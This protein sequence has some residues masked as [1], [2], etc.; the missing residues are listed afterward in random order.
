MSIIQEALKKAQ[1]DLKKRPVF[2]PIAY[3]NK[4]EQKKSVE[5]KPAEKPVPVYAVKAAA[6]EAAAKKP[7]PA[8][9]IAITLFAALLLAAGLV[10]TRYFM[11]VRKDGVLTSPELM[12]EAAVES[13][14]ESGLYQS[15]DAYKE[16]PLP[17]ADSVVVKP[18]SF[19]SRPTLGLNGIMYK[20]EN[21][22]A[23]VNNVIVEEGD[24]VMGAKVVKI[25]PKSVLLEYNG[26][27]ITLILK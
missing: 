25:N 10:S 5:E 1:T 21:P 7:F 13:P 14:V 17:P 22:K 20:E 18:E 24:T 12:R 23:I 16:L 19:A 8:K 15:V 2:Q 11:Q 27:E 9:V 6:V 4:I 26:T 3:P